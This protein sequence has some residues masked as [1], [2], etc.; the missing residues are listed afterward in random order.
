[1]SME[2]GMPSSRGDNLVHDTLG[3][4]VNLEKNISESKLYNFQKN[5]TDILTVE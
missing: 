5:R 2:R 3:E 4:K 1:M